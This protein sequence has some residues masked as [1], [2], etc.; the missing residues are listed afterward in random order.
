MQITYL[1]DKKQ[2]DNCV[3]EDAPLLL[4]VSFDGEQ[5]IVGMLDDYVEYNVLLAKAGLNSLDIDKYFRIV[6][7]KSGADW[8]F[9]CP[10]GYKGIEN[11]HQ[12]TAAFYRD[13]FS[14]L[15]N[16]LQ[17]LGYYVGINIP[18]RYRR[19]FTALAEN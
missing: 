9:V 11:S 4:L 18:P 13:G 7:D 16:T 5:A 6:L 1:P 2:F 19:H 3:A 10:P 8:T 12:R 17:K 14:I 15:A